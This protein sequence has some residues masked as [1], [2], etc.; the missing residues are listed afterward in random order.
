MHVY[1]WLIIAIFSFVL[2]GCGANNTLDPADKQEKGQIN[3]SKVS[4]KQPINQAPANRAKDMLSEHSE[5]TAIY[6]VNTDKQLL[7]T[8][9]IEHM[10]RFK[11]QKMKK[12]LTKKLQKAFPDLKVELSA[13]KKIIMEM[14]KLEKNLEEKQYSKKELKKEVKRIIDFSKEQT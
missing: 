7:A 11:L 6:A 4:T 3:L 1:K 5:I 13:D 12:Q 14:E 8:I 10:Q 2:V 9:E